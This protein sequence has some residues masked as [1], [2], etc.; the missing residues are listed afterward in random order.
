MQ[1]YDLGLTNEELIELK[2]SFE[3][4][5]IKKFNYDDYPEHVNLSSQDNGSYAWK[6]IIIK[7]TMNSVKGALIWMDAGNI[8]T[9]NL[10]IIKNYVNIFG[11]YSPLSSENIKKW[12]HPL[13]LEALKFPHNNLKKRNLNGAIVGVNNQSKYV[14]L[15]NKWEELSLK[16]EIIIPDG[17]NV[18]NHR[19]DQTLLTLLF[20]KDF[21]KAFFLRTYSV[22][23]IKVH[24]DID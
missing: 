14:N 19:W 12:S 4:I 5:N 15:V 24:Q 2:Q 23:G 3:N 11:F 20:Y 1:V 21:K 7:E 18:T 17:A 9:K 10:W 22:F 13:T 8:I 16:R 6:P